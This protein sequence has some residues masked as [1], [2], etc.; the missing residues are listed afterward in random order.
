VVRG[1]LDEEKGKFYCGFQGSKLGRRGI[2]R[3]SPDFFC[4]NPVILGLFIFLGC[5]IEKVCCSQES[6]CGTFLYNSAR[7]VEG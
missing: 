5:L 6:A 4:V 1:A 7:G 2:N 3:S